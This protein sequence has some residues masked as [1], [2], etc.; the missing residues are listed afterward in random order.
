MGDITM[1]T[2]KS[3]SERIVEFVTEISISAVIAVA[4][5]YGFLSLYALPI[6]PGA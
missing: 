6:I 3:T 1:E 2:R 5:I 4:S